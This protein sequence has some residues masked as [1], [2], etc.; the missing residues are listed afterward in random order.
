MNIRASTGEMLRRGSSLPLPYMYYNERNLL[1]R[2]HSLP[3]LQNCIDCDDSFDEQ[4]SC[5]FKSLCGG[6]FCMLFY[7]SKKKNSKN[8]LY[9][10]HSIRVSNNLDPDH[11]GH[12]VGPDLGRNC[13]QRLS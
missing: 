1:K 5:K 9:G 12:F 4:I 2:R 6:Y 10:T 8:N 13:L 3:Q 11:A 7:F